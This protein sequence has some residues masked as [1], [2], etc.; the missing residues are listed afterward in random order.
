MLGAQNSLSVEFFIGS[1]PNG[2]L[3]SIFEC[4]HE[5]PYAVETLINEYLK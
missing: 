5:A 2:N 4:K 3:Q 1:N